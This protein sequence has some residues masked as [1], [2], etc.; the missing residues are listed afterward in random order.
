[1]ALHGHTLIELTNTETGE[2][3]TIEDDNIVTNYIKETIL[4]RGILGIDGYTYFINSSGDNCKDVIL[5]KYTK[6]LLLFDTPIDE[7]PDM[8]SPPAGVRMTGHAGYNSYSGKD[9]SIG[10]YNEAESGKIENGFKHVWDFGTSQGNGPISCACLT[11]Q[12]GGILGAGSA[13]FDVSRTTFAGKNTCTKIGSGL[14]GMYS[15]G[16]KIDERSYSYAYPVRIDLE[17]NYF[18]C[19]YR[20]SDIEA[21]QNAFCIDN[22]SD[23]KPDNSPYITKTFIGERKLSLARVRMPIDTVNIFDHKAYDIDTRGV[24]EYFEIEMPDN[25]KQALDEFENYVLTQFS[26]RKYY[27]I[28]LNF[29]EE[30]VYITFSLDCHDYN[31]GLPLGGKSL[32]SFLVWEIDTVSKTS[33]AFKV[34]NGLPDNATLNVSP[35]WFFVTSKYLFAQYIQ[36]NKNYMC[37]ISLENS[38]EVHDVTDI[39]TGERVLFEIPTG[40]FDSVYYQNG[41]IYCKPEYNDRY[42][43]EHSSAKYPFYS[44]LSIMCIDTELLEVSYI[45]GFEQR[46]EYLDYMYPYSNNL[47]MGPRLIVPI[48]GSKLLYYSCLNNG[49]KGSEMDSSYSKKTWIF[50]P[51]PLV[52][53]NN[54]PQTVIK[55]TAET[56][57]VTYTVTYE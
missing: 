25:L 41:K 48:S 26:Q 47:F 27:Q 17:N 37:A 12:A 29:C 34:Y 33:K 44:R 32:P 8:M 51:C 39:R 57:K 14:G 18:D 6:G 5:E 23:L 56:M 16:E 15:K 13:Y 19:L 3:R 21:I 22:N 42:S 31:S 54:L 53:I 40:I 49:V 11:T 50:S 43:S 7:D 55:T 20:A 4:P 35:K 9:L 2:V 30:K 46:E 38:T 10:S 45:S 1:M 52:T 24:L 36:D 28:R